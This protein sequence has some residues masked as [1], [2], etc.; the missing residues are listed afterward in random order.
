MRCNGCDLISRAIHKAVFVF[1]N[2]SVQAEAR[3]G[4]SWDTQVHE[5]IDSKQT[6]LSI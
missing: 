2:A 5:Y 4:F 6:H 3:L 1:L